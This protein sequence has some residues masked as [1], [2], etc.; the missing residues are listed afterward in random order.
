[1]AL[2][3]FRRQDGLKLQKCVFDFFVYEHI[4]VFG[5]MADFIVCLCH[6]T[7][8]DFLGVLGAHPKASFQFASRWRQNENADDIIALLLELLRTLPV[9]VEEDVVAASKR[10]YHGRTR[11]SVM[12]AEH[13][14]I[15]KKGA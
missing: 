13:K 12:V 10:F 14:G 8:D 2:K 1:T 4:V 9:D 7:S 5:P 15:L 6:A 3:P 11:S